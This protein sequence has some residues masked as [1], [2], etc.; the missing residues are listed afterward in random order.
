M[1][2]IVIIT[3]IISPLPFHSPFIPF[4]FLSSGFSIISHV[5][6]LSPEPARVSL[7][8]EELQSRVR[9]LRPKDTDLNSTSVTY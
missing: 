8:H 1:R 9:L 7:S 2:V 3:A 6:K 4:I 5:S